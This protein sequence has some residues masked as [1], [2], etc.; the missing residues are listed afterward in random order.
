LVFNIVIIGFQQTGLSPKRT[1]SGLY[2][3]NGWD[4]IND[5]DGFH[6]VNYLTTFDN[7]PFGFIA[8]ANDDWNTEGL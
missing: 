4:S 8:T 5:W 2:P 3:L 6:S 7:P 1:N